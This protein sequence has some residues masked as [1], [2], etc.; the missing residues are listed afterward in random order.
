MFQ[1]SQKNP[2]SNPHISCQMDGIEVQTS[3]VSPYNPVKVGGVETSNTFKV[4]VTR[5]DGDANQIVATFYI[6]HIQKP[7][8]P[9][10][11][12]TAYE[13][14][15]SKVI[16][17]KPEQN[18]WQELTIYQGDDGKPWL[19]IDENTSIRLSGYGFD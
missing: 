3:P 15:E 10:V 13:D 14:S 12:S 7:K 1:R 4:F 8:I 18:P 6:G 9:F 19:K 16:I 5:T 11:V 2:L 17:L